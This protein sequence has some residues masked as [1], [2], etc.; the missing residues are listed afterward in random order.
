MLSPIAPPRILTRSTSPPHG[1]M[2]CPACESLPDF[3]GYYLCRQ[4]RVLL[5]R[6]SVRR[7]HLLRLPRPAIATDARLW[8][9]VR[10]RVDWYVVAA[11]DQG[12]LRWLSAPEA[13]EHGEQLNRG[14]G[15]QVAVELSRWRYQGQEPLPLG[16][17]G[18]PAPPAAA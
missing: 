3:R 7:G 16:D 17:T 13:E 2:P 18:P 5:R 15:V 8:H 1:S 14:W 6:L 11:A 4:R 10:P 9:R 12:W